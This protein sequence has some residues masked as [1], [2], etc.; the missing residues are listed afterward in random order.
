MM[1]QTNSEQ[2]TFDFG[3]AL[4]AGLQAGD[5]VLLTGD[6]G[7]G[8]SVVARGV[9]SAHGVTE[10]MPSPTFVLMI[11]HEGDLPVY[12]FDLYRLEDPDEFYQAGLQE[13]LGGARY[14]RDRM[15]GMRQHRP[16]RCGSGGGIAGRRGR[17]APHSGESP[18][19]PLKIASLHGGSTE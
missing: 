7:A 1:Y 13:Y 17:P 10:A 12:H 5:C 3:A 9:A 8:K 6:L 11:P 4:G 19:K 2:E 18:G 14:C 16:A 15:A